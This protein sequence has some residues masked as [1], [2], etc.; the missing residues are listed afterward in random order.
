MLV[1]DAIDLALA[2]I[3]TA[4]PRVN[5]RALRFLAPLGRKNAAIANDDRAYHLNS[6][7]HEVSLDRAPNA[8]VAK[9]VLRSQSS[10]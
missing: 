1:H 5:N 2:V 7:R 6:F 8:L 3:G 4:E 10:R 9:R